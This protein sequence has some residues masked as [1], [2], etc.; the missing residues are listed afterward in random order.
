MNMAISLQRV[1]SKWS[2]LQISMV[3]KTAFIKKSG[4]GLGVTERESKGV[5]ECR[6]WVE[7][8]L[9]CVSAA[10]GCH[11]LWEPGCSLLLC[12]G[13][14]AEP[15]GPLRLC[16]PLLRAGVQTESASSAIRCCQPDVVTSWAISVMNC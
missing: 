11:P 2:N 15:Q 8:G 7:L 1:N 6:E 5:P 13:L 14:G 9:G 4:K 10:G 3:L 16:T 12:S